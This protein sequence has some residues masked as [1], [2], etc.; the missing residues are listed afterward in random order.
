MFNRFM[1]DAIS[2]FDISIFFF[3]FVKLQ[4][5][6]TYNSFLSTPN[7]SNSLGYFSMILCNSPYSFVLNTKQAII[8]THKIIITNLKKCPNNIIIVLLVGGLL[9][10]KIIQILIWIFNHP[11]QPLKIIFVNHVMCRGGMPCG[12]CGIHR[13]QKEF[14]VCCDKQQGNF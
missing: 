13:R 8:P 10:F 6:G 1:R 2:S 12:M 7:L 4:N 3:I 5:S 14:L 9:Y 11:V